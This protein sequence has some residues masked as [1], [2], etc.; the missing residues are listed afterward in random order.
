MEQFNLWS[1]HRDCLDGKGDPKRRYFSEQEA[2]NIAAYLH[3]ERGL[4]LYVYKCENCKYWHLT[5]HCSDYCRT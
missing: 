1:N 3:T 2:R 4:L 5:R